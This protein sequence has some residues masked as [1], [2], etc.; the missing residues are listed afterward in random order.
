ME[1]MARVKRVAPDAAELADALK[2]G[3]DEMAQGATAVRYDRRNDAVILV[4][5]SG[6]IAMIP[7]S[8]IPIVADAERSSLGGVELSPMG[9]SLRFPRLDADFAVQGLIRCV[10]QV[11]EANRIAGGTKSAARAAASRVNGRKGGRPRTKHVRP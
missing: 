1:K 3:R 8:L 5:R 11:N 6:A 2:R 7:R 9:T 4:M 10:F